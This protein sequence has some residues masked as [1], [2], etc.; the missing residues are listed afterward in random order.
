MR[1]V[2][3]CLALVMAL[4]GTQRVHAL[5]YTQPGD[6]DDFIIEASR[7]DNVQAS[8]SHLFERSRVS[9]QDTERNVIASAA[10]VTHMVELPH[11]NTEAVRRSNSL[12]VQRVLE[13]TQTRLSHQEVRE[14]DL[15]SLLGDVSEHY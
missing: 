14:M 15:L 5:L 9:M 2:I 13:R 3:L 10:E 8:G 6:A 7:G 1:K 11:E 4:Y 12:F